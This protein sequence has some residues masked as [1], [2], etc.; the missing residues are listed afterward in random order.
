M[1]KTLEILERAKKHIDNGWIKRDLE[2]QYGV[3]S[4]GAIN[5]ATRDLYQKYGWADNN[6]I[7]R[8]AETAVCL[9]ATTIDPKAENASLCDQHLKIIFFNDVP[10]R[11]KGG[12]RRKFKK[13]IKIAKKC[14]GVGG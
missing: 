5:K 8:A 13:A 12:V 4:I 1:S 9:L 14:E 6:E 11:M 7:R 3:C 2:N 10:W